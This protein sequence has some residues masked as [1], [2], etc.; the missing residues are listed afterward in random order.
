[1]E[2]SAQRRSFP[3]VPKSH[4]FGC[5]PCSTLLFRVTDRAANSVLELLSLS[6]SPTTGTPT[7]VQEQR[8]LIANFSE[9][10]PEVLSLT[11]SASGQDASTHVQKPS[12]LGTAW[13]RRT[14]QSPSPPRPLAAHIRLCGNN[15][16]TSPYRSS[17]ADINSHGPGR[18]KG[19][20]HVHST[21]STLVEPA[22]FRRLELS[23]TMVE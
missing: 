2:F 4:V 17:G 22:P 16:S 3:W 15:P 6:T 14:L 1:M 8:L 12:L 10:R 20:S 7:L 9:I 5:M 11:R 21:L 13:K 18:L 19:L 23:K